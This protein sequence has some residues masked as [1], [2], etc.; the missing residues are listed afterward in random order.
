M[1]S[2]LGLDDAAGG[3]ETT[4]RGWSRIPARPTSSSLAA[5]Y[6]RELIFEGRLRSGQRVPQDDVARALGLSRIPV[7]EAIIALEREGFVTTQLHRGA[8]VS[9]LDEDAVRDQYEL[10]GRVYGF[11]AMRALERSDGAFID[12]LQVVEK[13]LSKADDAAI[14]AELAVEYARI[15]IDAAASPRIKL[16]IRAMPGLAPATFF[17]I[18]PAAMDVT[19]RGNRAVLKALEQGD[20]PLAAERFVVMMGEIGDHVVALFHERQLFTTDGD[21]TG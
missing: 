6:I 14:F 21:G 20:G 18:M 12:E 4:G 9:A 16:V 11:A 3:A 5:E 7:R 13:R 1:R 8:F 19:K 10:Y 15:I 17:S 2:S